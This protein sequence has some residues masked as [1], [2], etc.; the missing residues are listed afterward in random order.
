MSYQCKICNNTVGN[1]PYTGRE[2][3]FGTGDEFSYFKCP[4]CGCLQIEEVPDSLDK[5]YP[6]NYYSYRQKGTSSWGT[7]RDSLIHSSAQWGIDRILPIHLLSHKYAKYHQ[8][9]QLWLKGVDK[10]TSILDIGSGKGVLLN[11]LHVFGY[12][13]LTGIDPYIDGDV[14]YDNGVRIFKKDIYDLD[15]QYDFVMLHHAFEHIADPHKSISRLSEIVTDNGRILIRI[16]VV[17][18]YAWRKYQMD[19]FQVDAPRHLFLYS[20]KSMRMLA[21]EHGLEIESIIYDSEY[22][23]FTISDGYVKGIS[24]SEMSSPSMWEKYR[25]KRKAAQLNL[26]QDGDQ[27]CFILRKKE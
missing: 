1:I 19:W 8:Y 12:E 21:E 16:P 23:Q 11:M 15:K 4:V 22:R 10:K 5:Y 25:Y 27:A 6:N 20:V 14:S 7:L 3:M 13:N 26:S 17:D 2:M 9:K 18:G 24:A